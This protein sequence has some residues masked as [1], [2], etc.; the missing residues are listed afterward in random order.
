MSTPP[1]AP[2]ILDSTPQSKGSGSHHNYASEHTQ[3]DYAPYLREDLAHERTITVAQFFEWILRITNA[4]DTSRTENDHTFQKYLAKYNQWDVYERE[5]QLY[6][7]FVELA[8]Y[9]IGNKLKFNSVA[10]T[11]P[12]SSGKPDVVSIWAAA[13]ALGARTSADN[14]ADGGPGKLSPFHW[15]ELIAFWEFKFVPGG[16]DPVTLTSSL[17]RDPFLT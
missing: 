10:M 5:T 13:L 4:Q 7:P 11:R 12:V 3:K 15:M 2:P 6:Q 16:V 14:L 9:C 8:N 1:S 17:A